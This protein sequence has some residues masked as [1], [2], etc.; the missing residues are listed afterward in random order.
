[1]T[2]QPTPQTNAKGNPSFPSRQKSEYSFDWEVHDDYS[3]NDFGHH[4]S[5]DGYHT[6]GGYHVLLPDGRVKRVTYTV[7]EDGGYLATVEYEGEIKHD[8]YG[9]PPAHTYTQAPA[10]GPPPTPAY[11]HA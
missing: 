4:E 6:E 7:T 2:L 1:M 11:G 10:Y 3:G 9:K 8:H 5:G